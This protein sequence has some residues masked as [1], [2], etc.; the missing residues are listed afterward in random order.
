MKFK[1]EHAFSGITPDEYEKLYFDEAFNDELC[2]AVEL[3]RTL[4]KKDVK[5]KHLSRAVK[6]SPKREIPAPAAKILGSS[7]LEYTEYV[8]YD[9]GSFKG[10]WKTVSAIM[11]DKIESGG[12]F[13]FTKKGDGIVRVLDGDIK[14]KIFGVGGVV[15]KFIVMDVEKSYDRAAEFTRRWLARG[16]KV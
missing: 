2:K 12:T 3:E 4:I 16:G 11:S 6:V 13:Q 15:E 5:G 8:E 9:L 10:T 1:V 14:V 7:K